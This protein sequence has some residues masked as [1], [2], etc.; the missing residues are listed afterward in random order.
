MPLD[1]TFYARIDSNSSGGGSLNLTGA[2]AVEMTFITDPAAGADGDLFLE[3]NGGAA[4][5]DT[6]VSIGG[7]DYN[8][9]IQFAGTL[10]TAAN[11]GAGQVPDQLEGEPV[12]LITIV[13]YPSAGQTTRL[14]FLPETDPTE[15]EMNAFGTGA[16]RIDNFTTSPPPLAVCFAA[17]TLIQ[18]P[19]GAVKIDKLVAGDLVMTQD[20]GPQPIVW[21]AQSQHS[22]PGS[23][24]GCKPIL[25]AA[26][27]L[28][29]GRPMHDLQVSP[30]H[31]VLMSN[32]I[33]AAS[34]GQRDV[35]APAKGLIGLP[36]VR[37]MKGKKAVTYFHMLL[38]RHAIVW[39]NGAETESFYP[40]PCAV[41][42]LTP[43]HKASLFRLLPGVGAQPVLR[44]G[45]TAR[46]RITKGQT[47]QLVRALRASQTPVQQPK[48]QLRLVS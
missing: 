29:D 47:V 39:S 5:P 8:F 34:F 37:E 2:P 46:L 3:S 14:M 13:G 40:G 25:I 22:W 33:C 15:A 26:G 19:R 17:G 9:T 36:G 35:L 1:T 6:L 21:V 30:Q 31:H 10:P 12:Y 38:P 20:A 23:D 11:R 4:D 48:V 16:I 32:P 27:A 18:T 28:G 43:A 24:E 7:T 41:A 45:P 44:Y 42:M